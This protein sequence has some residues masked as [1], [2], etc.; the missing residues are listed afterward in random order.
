MEELGNCINCEPL[1]KTTRATN[2]VE[3]RGDE[4]PLCPSC[5]YEYINSYVGV[6]LN[7]LNEG[8]ED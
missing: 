8:P 3:I 6:D 2:F 5:Y 7:L 1:G 4:I